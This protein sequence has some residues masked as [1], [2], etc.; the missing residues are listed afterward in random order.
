MKT[1]ILFLL[2]AIIMILT[3]CNPG[4][5]ENANSNI[6]ESE[7][8]NI[9]TDINIEI[10]DNNDNKVDASTIKGKVICGYQGWFGTPDDGYPERGWM[11]WNGSKPS[12]KNGKQ[13]V[14]FEMFPDLWEYNPEH[15]FPI[16]FDDLPDGRPAALFSSYREETVDL[17]FKWMQEYGIDGVALQRFLGEAVGGRSK[18]AD[19]VAAHVKS[20]CEKYGRIFYIC[21][22]F[23]GYNKDD[24][25]A[26]VKRD[27]EKTVEGKLGLISSDRYLHHSGKP[28]VQLW[29]MGVPGNYKRSPEESLEI[30][31]FFK[32]R[33]YYVIGGAPTDW[34][35]NSGDVIKGF[36]DVYDEFDMISPWAVGRFGNASEAKSHY[37]TKNVKDLE[38]TKNTGQD[39]MPVIFPGFAWSLW[40]GGTKNQIPRKAGDFMRAQMELALDLNPTAV[41]IA[42]FDEYDEGTAVM[43]AASDSSEIPAN[44]YFLT[45]SADGAYVSSDYYLRLVGAFTKNFNGGEKVDLNIPN[46]A[47]PIWFKTGFEKGTDAQLKIDGSAAVAE[48]IETD[49]AH[50]GKYVLSVDFSSGACPSW[51]ELFKTDIPISENTYFSYY[52]YVSDQL[53]Y[54]PSG[55]PGVS[56]NMGFDVTV[57]GKHT[58]SLYLDADYSKKGEWV[59]AT[60]NL[61]GL[62]TELGAKRITAV[63][64]YGGLWPFLIDDICIWDK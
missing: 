3:S 42:M 10:N 58:T 12:N 49:N 7:T 16:A 34:R 29:G 53:E 9:I 52:I 62:I 38:R 51:R 18:H 32:D 26:A 20:A 31:K 64:L 15:L 35:K 47:G 4:E 56:R 46:S 5:I 39:Y 1:R 19:T 22:D 55:T 13:S 27:F 14:S 50:N 21:Y 8:D 59:E 45:T 36:K 2:C 24:Y 37:K 33:G 25:V 60:Y 6:T 40:N 23:S 63:H 11:H 54:N 57:D 48:V 61:G 43:K 17:H 28:V 30:I 41:Y 44:S